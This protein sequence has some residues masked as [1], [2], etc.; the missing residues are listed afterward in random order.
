MSMAPASEEAEYSSVAG[1]PQED[2]SVSYWLARG[3]AQSLI[4]LNAKKPLPE[5]VDV[6]IIGSGIA[7]TVA[8]Y[9]LMAPAET[10]PDDGFLPS[11]YAGFEKSAPLRVAMLEAREISSGATGRNGGHVRP[12]VFASFPRF[13]AFLGDEMAHK[14][15]VNERET[16]EYLA[17]LVTAE[18]IQCDFNHCTTA[19]VFLSEG[20]MARER[21]AFD[22]YTQWGGIDSDV[23]FCDSPEEAQRVT[24]VKGALGMATWAAASMYPY[25]FATSLVSH[26]IQRGLDVYTQAPVDKIEQLLDGTWKATLAARANQRGGTVRARQVLLATNAYTPHLVPIFKQH[27]YPRRA[28]CSAIVPTKSFSGMPRQPRQGGEFAQEG[29]IPY[30]FSIKTSTFGYEYF[31]PRPLG[32]D[33]TWILGGASSVLS[34]DQVVRSSTDDSPGLAGVTCGGTDDPEARDALTRVAHFFS[35]FPQ[36]HFN[37]W[38]PCAG[39]G[40]ERVWSGILGYTKDSLP[41]VPRRVL[42][43]LA[44]E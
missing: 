33:G 2:G 27:V 30:T 4:G 18:Q 37:G 11:V 20:A 38:S 10:G 42:L 40:L 16:L 35:E 26:L 5:E 19:D 25:R 8:A 29:I 31:V 24:R 12:D 15:L 28:W 1:L 21:N 43:G 34:D 9:N 32:S 3:K 44:F 22:Q 36:K 23:R 41:C 14:V 7:G 39:E 17:Q 6:L 13:S